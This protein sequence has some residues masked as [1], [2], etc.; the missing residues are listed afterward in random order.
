MSAICK[1]MAARSESGNWVGCEIW[2]G[3]TF[4]YRRNTAPTIVAP[5]EVGSCNGGSREGGRVKLVLVT[6]LFPT[7]LSVTS[8]QSRQG[9]GVP[10]SSIKEAA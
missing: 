9:Y 6:P 4:F 1:Q 8:I 2:R 10:S 5:E 3:N 7:P